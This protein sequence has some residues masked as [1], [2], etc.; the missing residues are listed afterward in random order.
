MEGY[1]L[2][3]CG[4]VRQINEDAGGVFFNKAKQALAVVADGMGG[5][6]AGEI[7]SDLAVKTVRENYEL[8]T[9]FTKISDSEKWIK[10]M[11]EKMNEDVY[12]FATGDDSLTGMG[13][14]VVLALCTRE[15][16]VIGHVGDSRCYLWNDET[17]FS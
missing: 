6:Q 3:D 2:T 10:T 15:F 14:T 4:K 16:V 8:T 13:T 1:F 7:A 5:H 12:Q 9:E 11:I 17:A